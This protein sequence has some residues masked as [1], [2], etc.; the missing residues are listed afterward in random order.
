MSNFS[1]LRDNLMDAAAICENEQ[2][3]VRA[4]LKQAAG[5]MQDAHNLG[6]LT[7][8]VLRHMLAGNRPDATMLERLQAVLSLNGFTASLE[9]TTKINVQEDVIHAAPIGSDIVLE[10]EHLLVSFGD[11]SPEMEHNIELHNRPML[12]LRL[13]PGTY[14]FERL[15]KNPT[16]GYMNFVS[17]ITLLIDH[18]G[19]VTKYVDR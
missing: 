8:Q 15:F 14:T 13:Q 2:R 18:H 12:A 10:T 11:K 19:T 7:E 1:A 16:N 6:E 3:A 17:D 9:D 4:R 5:M